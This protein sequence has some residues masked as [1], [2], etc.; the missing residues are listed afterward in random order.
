VANDITVVHVGGVSSR[1]R[2]LWVEWQK[3]GSLWRYFRKFEAAQTPAWLQPV[4]WV[5]VWGHFLAAALRAW[6]RPL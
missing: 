4:L 2:P 5:G 1:A 6:V 3:H